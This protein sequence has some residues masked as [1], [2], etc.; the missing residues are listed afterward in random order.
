VFTL[1]LYME[2]VKVVDCCAA[3]GS[4]RVRVDPDLL[5]GDRH[6]GTDVPDL[7]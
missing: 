2:P 5:C 6:T 1:V 3:G 7:G 4:L